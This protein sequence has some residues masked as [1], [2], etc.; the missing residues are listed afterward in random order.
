M[1]KGG[2]MIENLDENGYLVDLEGWTAEVAVQVA[3][4]ES[5]EKLTEAH[6]VIINFVRGYYLDYQIPPMEKIIVKYISLQQNL[7]GECKGDRVVSKELLYR[8]FPNEVPR[9]LICKIGGLP[10]PESCF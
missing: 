6:W 9:D 1:Y 2:Q 8:L 7:V 10:K 3:Q 5:I 4:K